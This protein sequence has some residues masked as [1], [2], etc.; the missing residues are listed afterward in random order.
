MLL[1]VGE[2]NALDVQKQ[3]N[4]LQNHVNFYVCCGS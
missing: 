2:G 3:N 1:V 4:A